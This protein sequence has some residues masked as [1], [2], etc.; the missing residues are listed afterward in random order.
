MSRSATLTRILRG[1]FWGGLGMAIVVAAL[2]VGWRA[3]AAAD[4]GYPVFYELLDIERTIATYG[5]ENDTRPGFHATSEAERERIFAAI[6]DAVRG[7]GR[8]LESIRYSLPAGQPVPVLTA[9]EIQH[10]RDVAA[11][12]TA[13]ERTGWAAMAIM[14]GLLGVAW[15][16]LWQPPSTRRFAAGVALVAGAGTL[17][18]LGLGPMAVFYWLHERIFPPE[19]QWF[20][21][22]EESLMSMLMQAP[23]LFGAIAVAWLALTVVLACGGWALGRALVSH[24]G[25]TK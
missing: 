3:L 23:N 7:Q 15:M 5:P 12:V 8:G 24:K 16:R 2:F 10:L 9:A 11:L 4:F 21:W 18:V 25:T 6:A 20:F 17:V 1:A 13:F 14:A 22:Y 19:H